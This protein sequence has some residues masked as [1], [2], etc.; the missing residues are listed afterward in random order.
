MRV[1]G[2]Y[3]LA[4]R[5]RSEGRAGAGRGAAR[6]RAGSAGVAVEA[7][8]SDV[9]VV[10]PYTLAV[11]L[12]IAGRLR[13]AQDAAARGVEAARKEGLQRRYGMDLAALEGD[14]L[15]RVGRWDEAAEVMDAGLAL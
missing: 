5:P 8:P 1:V 3:H 11:N 9:R 15:T 13:E 2:P 14:V 6:E 10:G 7:G 4:G 12:A